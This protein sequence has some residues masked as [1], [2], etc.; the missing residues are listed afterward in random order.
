MISYLAT[1]SDFL[2]DAPVI[3]DKVRDA[4]KRKFNLSVGPSEYASWRNSLGNAM[5][6]VINNSLIPDEAGVGVEYRVN[7]RKYRIDFLITGK[8]KNGRNSV[9]IIELKQWTEIEFSELQDHVRTRLGG[10]LSDERHPSYQ[11]WSYA[12]HLQDFNEFVYE[13]KVQIMS[14][15]YLHNC[16]DKS[17]LQNS[18]Y[19][20]F[21][22]EAPVFLKGEIE[23]LRQHIS[24]SIYEGNGVGLLE[25]IDSSP[26][27]P[28]K[29]LAE[30]VSSMLSGNQEF[31]LLDDQKT[32]LETIIN[33]T[34]K[35]LKG[36]KEVIIIKGG[37]GTGKSVVAINAV[38][39][40]TAQ[41]LNTQYVTQNSAPRTVYAEKLGQTSKD[42]NHKNLFSSAGSFVNTSID[43][44]DALIID[45]SHRLNEKSGFYKNLGTNQIKEI[46][47]SSKTSVF[48]IDEA[49]K[50]T[51]A[52]IGEISEIEKFAHEAGANIKHLELKS[53]FRCSGS[54]DYLAWLDDALG[55]QPNADHFFSTSRFDFQIIDSPSELQE[56]IL[57]KN[58]LNNRA[59]LVAGYCW[60]WVSKKDARLNDIVF[61]EFR[62][63]MKWNLASYAMK[64]IIEKDSVNEIGCIHTCQGL[65]MDYVGVIIGKD[66]IYRDGELI[67]DPSA[68]AKT[69]GSL[70][71]YKKFRK[72][73][74]AEADV[75]AD[76]IIRNTYRTLMTR[77]MKGCY[78]YFAD[79]ATSDYF[80]SLIPKN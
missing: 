51:W 76:E 56:I 57:A 8:D 73:N 17:V 5:F 9:S 30:A 72:E 41:R 64:W 61:P 26:I 48:F 16:N 49:Q 78:V 29:Q 2:K 47:D 33:T 39:R 68:R 36:N 19:E 50:V 58:E 74:S 10:G 79:K 40:L 20:N 45:E 60:D 44:F 3:E 34:N 67:T 37:P 24:K 42:Q 4:V 63:A 18:R 53:Q 28:S 65:E 75:R 80:K 1:K 46:I 71:G 55:V 32:V 23:E 25:E 14:S 54:D 22:R 59:R 13:N 70:K 38:A 62:F 66:L 69:D 21:L 7:G 6:H 27:R 12:R 35:S 52:D 11:A 43:S 77:G 31:I 15:A